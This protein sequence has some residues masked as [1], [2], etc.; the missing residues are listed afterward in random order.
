MPVAQY[1]IDAVVEAARKLN[2]PVWLV[3]YS[4]DWEIPLEHFKVEDF[5]PALVETLVPLLLRTLR[6]TGL[7][8]AAC[9]QLERDDIKR[10]W[11]SLFEQE[12]AAIE[13]LDFSTWFENPQFVPEGE[14]FRRKYIHQLIQV[15]RT[16]EALGQ[17][18][19]HSFF[20]PLE[21]TLLLV[22]DQL[23]SLIGYASD[24][25][26][27]DKISRHERISAQTHNELIEIREAVLYGMQWDSCDNFLMRQ[28]FISLLKSRHAKT[29]TVAEYEALYAGLLNDALEE[30][31]VFDVVQTLWPF[32]RWNDATLDAA[33]HSLF[34]LATTDE[35]YEWAFRACVEEEMAY[36]FARE[37]EVDEGRL[38][39]AL[40]GWV[41]TKALHSERELIYQKMLAI[42]DEDFAPENV[43]RR[44][45]IAFTSEQVMNN[46]ADR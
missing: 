16:I 42:F 5:P 46:L 24:L 20:E 23:S 36:F 17:V 2:L 8:Q 13:Q 34:Q 14:A 1:S 4:H 27:L 22:E 25:E 18:E 29:D 15:T 19:A 26:E 35:D 44:R 28:E 40:Q 37:G 41:S 33:T 6:T 11:T 21:E 12:I 32:C 30:D 3:L 45:V 39:N 7:A 9:A 43:F 31:S 10:I 38:F